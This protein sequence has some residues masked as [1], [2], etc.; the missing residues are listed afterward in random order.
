MRRWLAT[1]A[2]MAAMKRTA[3]GAKQSYQA[4]PNGDDAVRRRRSSANRV[5]NMLKAALNHAF[6][7]GHITNRDAWGRKLKPFRDVDTARVR[8]LTVAQA[9]RVINSSDPDFRPL[10]IAALQTGCRYSELTRLRVEDFNPDS[11]T[12]A[13]RQSKS[14][15]SR[16]VELTDE[17][18]TFFTQ[19]TAGRAGSEVM[20]QRTDGGRW[21]PSHQARPMIDACQRAK[22]E[23]IGIH[24]LRHT[25]ASLSAMS[26][27]PL[28]VIAKNL[29]HADTRMVD[30]HY[31]HLAPSYIRDAIRAGAPRFGVETDKK[32]AT[33]GSKQ[34]FRTKGAR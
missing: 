31:G 5:M 14:G 21:G 13:I 18:V 20:F 6:D 3:R 22:I 34:T 30:R 12:I 24:G 32:V 9:Q 27:V 15:K 28:L 10:V 4:E 19:M 2:G 11:E 29:G 17:G 7:E 1:L 16:H 25:Y 33:L 26:G 8:Y 23:P